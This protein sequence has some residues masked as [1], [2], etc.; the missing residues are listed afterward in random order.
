VNTDLRIGFKS[1]QGLS[2]ENN[3]DS[4]LVDEE[5]GF[6]IVADGMGGHNAGEIASRM[7]VTKISDTIRKQLALG[8]GPVDAIKEAVTEA[9]R[10]IL[11]SAAR[12][13]ECADM[14]TTVV[15]ALISDHR[16]TISHVGD[17][18]AYLIRNGHIV[19]LTEDHSFVAESLKRGFIT[20]EQAKTH[21]SRHGLT[22][23]LGIEDEVEPETTEVSWD[24]EGCILLCSDG[25]TDVLDDSE[26]REIIRAA[27]NPQAGCDALIE[28][29]T[30]KGNKDDVTVILVC[31]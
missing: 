28:T 23:A 31:E 30:Q 5:L 4:Y 2:R 9:N 25:L 13:P 8:K 15:L 20:P 29:A 16:I 10:V 1:L 14:G 7:A 22:M 18:R 11:D 24:N 6:F 19:Q 17:S 21:Q 26:I 3:E 27:E 12:L